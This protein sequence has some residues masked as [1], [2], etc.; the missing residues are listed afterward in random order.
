MQTYNCTYCGEE[1]EAYP[2]QDRKYCSRDCSYEHR[3]ERTNET[4]TCEHCGE[5]YE[6]QQS[7]KQKYCSTDCQHKARR[8]RVTSTCEECGDEFERRA[9]SMERH[10][11]SGKYCSK[12]CM[13]AGTIEK[14]FEC[15]TCG[16]EFTRRSGKATRSETQYCSQECYGK[17][18]QREVRDG[19]IQCA[20]CEE[21]L[22]L[23]MFL[24]RG[25]DAGLG[26]VSYCRACWTKRE[27][28]REQWEAEGEVTGQQLYEI[29]RAQDS[30]CTYC[31]RNLND[32]ET[33]VDHIT[34]R[35]KGGEH[36]PGNVHWTCRQCNIEKNDKTHETFTAGLDREVDLSWHPYID[37]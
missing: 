24:D 16:D 34:P 19:N 1:F 3:K 7:R 8:N 21:W 29:R 13:D 30:D 26:K 9:S 2:S 6:V 32:L 36:R 35:T 17:D 11:T 12:E 10:D 33:H 18:I 5:D 31:G 37:Q 28:E 4:R 22:P 23:D 20:D 27:Q 15:P 25:D 14:T